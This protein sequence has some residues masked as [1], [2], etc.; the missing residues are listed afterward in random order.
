MAAARTLGIASQARA[1][2]QVI[3][4]KQPEAASGILI[5]SA[6]WLHRI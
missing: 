5:A 2:V 6:R 4:T 3:A 1:D